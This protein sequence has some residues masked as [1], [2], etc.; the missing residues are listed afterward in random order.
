MNDSGCGFLP[1]WKNTH[2][3]PTGEFPTPHASKRFFRHHLLQIG[4]EFFKAPHKQAGAACTLQ[5]LPRPA[6]RPFGL[7]NTARTRRR[8]LCPQGGEQR[9]GRSFVASRALIVLSR[10]RVW[11]VCRV[12][13]TRFSLLFSRRTGAADVCTLGG[14]FG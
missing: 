5:T 4:T 6:D 7:S 14:V 9:S 11:S 13:T 12:R 8:I 10:R 3:A 1:G 2:R